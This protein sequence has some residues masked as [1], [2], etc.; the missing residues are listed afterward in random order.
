MSPSND[1]ANVLGYAIC[2]ED[3]CGWKGPITAPIRS[4]FVRCPDCGSL[5]GFM[6]RGKGVKIS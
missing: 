2:L 1:Q 4:A 6:Y 3:L 5:A